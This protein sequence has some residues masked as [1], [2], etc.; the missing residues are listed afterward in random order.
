V[1]L[2]FNCAPL[3]SK[4]PAADLN[5]LAVQCNGLYIGKTDNQCKNQPFQISARINNILKDF[6][7]VSLKLGLAPLSNSK[8]TQ[9]SRPYSPAHSKADYKLFINECHFKY[10]T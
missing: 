3:S 9:S 6:L 5:F 4:I 8:C 2:A 1:D 7:T 10:P